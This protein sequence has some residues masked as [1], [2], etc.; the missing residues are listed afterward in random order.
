MAKV[1]IHAFTQDENNKALPKWEELSKLLGDCLGGYVSYID[2][3][4]KTND[5]TFEYDHLA[6]HHPNKRLGVLANKEANDGS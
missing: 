6:E 5:T 2:V 1:I 3:V 4:D